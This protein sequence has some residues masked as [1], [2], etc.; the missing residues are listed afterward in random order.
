MGSL[1][2]SPDTFPVPEQVKQVM[3][4]Q[5]WLSSPD[6]PHVG[7][8]FID[9]S[10]KMGGDALRVRVDGGVVRF[11]EQRLDLGQVWVRLDE[12]AE[13]GD[14]RAADISRAEHPLLE[15]GA[16]VEHVGELRQDLVHEAHEP[17][18]Q[19]VLALVGTDVHPV[20]Q[21]GQ[22]GQVGHHERQHHGV[23]GVALG[24]PAELVQ[25]GP[26]DAAEG[27]RQTRKVQGTRKPADRARHG[28]ILTRH[29]DMSPSDNTGLKRWCKLELLPAFRAQEAGML[30]WLMVG[31]LAQDVDRGALVMGQQAAAISVSRDE[32]NAR[33][34]SWLDMKGDELTLLRDLHTP[35]TDTYVV[36]ARRGFDGRGLLF[37]GSLD[38]MVW[39]EIL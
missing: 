25:R 2:G 34:A 3:E 37:D 33:L 8:V 5:V 36:S 28:L 6:P 12:L 38:M 24:L 26:L 35:E 32:M 39:V 17:S 9:T 18:L 30:A 22:L 4:M 19:R 14:V 7:H 11:G 29:G 31:A 21:A 23:V 16:G 15:R 20:L 13:L 10:L 1:A 27:Q